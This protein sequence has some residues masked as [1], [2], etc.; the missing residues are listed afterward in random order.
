MVCF[1][2]HRIAPTAV[3]TIACLEVLRCR[4]IN[5][6]I[7]DL[8]DRLGAALGLMTRLRRRR[9]ARRAIALN[10]KAGVSLRE[11]PC[12]LRVFARVYL[13][14]L[15]SPGEGVS[16]QSLESLAAVLDLSETQVR[17]IRRQVERGVA[18]A[19]TVVANREEPREVR[20]SVGPRF[21][22]TDQGSSWTA[23]RVSQLLAGLAAVLGFVIGG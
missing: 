12:P 9:L 10:K 2:K 18:A 4:E 15:R 1:R 16:N 3:Y 17:S 11:A 8:V 22:I 6:S 19:H 23:A 20:P 13:A 7:S 21:A 14:H 5:H